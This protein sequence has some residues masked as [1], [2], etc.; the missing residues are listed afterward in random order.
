MWICWWI[1]PFMDFNNTE[2]FANFHIQSINK[3]ETERATTKS[4]LFERKEYWIWV[5]LE[6]RLLFLQTTKCEHC[7]YIH[8]R[9]RLLTIDNFETFKCTHAKTNIQLFSIL[10]FFYASYLLNLPIRCHLQAKL[11]RVSER[12]NHTNAPQQHISWHLARIFAYSFRINLAH[13]QTSTMP[14][15]LQSYIIILMDVNWSNDCERKLLFVGV[16]ENILCA[17]CHKNGN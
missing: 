6:Q 10:W 1:A 4:D 11:E 5:N 13:M 14:G 12:E 3:W 15:K 17:K 9:K 8:L 16:N 7:C 2:K